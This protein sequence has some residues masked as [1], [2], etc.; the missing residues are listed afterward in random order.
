METALDLYM[1]AASIASTL[2]TNDLTERAPWRPLQLQAENDDAPPSPQLLRRRCR[3]VVVE[4][5][6]VSGFGVGLLAK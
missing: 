6:L 3:V 2:M 4:A 5:L 1:F